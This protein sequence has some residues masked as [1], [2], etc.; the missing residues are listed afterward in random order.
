VGVPYSRTL[1][2]TGGT[3]NYS[4][5]IVPGRGQTPQGLALS[6]SGVLSGTPTKAQTE[7]FWVHVTSGTQQERREL[8]IKVR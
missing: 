1:R 3:G 6:P 7:E 2:A 5:S 4:W 8:S